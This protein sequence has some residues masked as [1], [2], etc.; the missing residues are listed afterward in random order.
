[1]DFQSG[2]N[3]NNF[4]NPLNGE[5]FQAPQNNGQYGYFPPQNYYGQ[6]PQYNQYNQFMPPNPMPP[7]QLPQYPPFVQMPTVPDVNRMYVDP[8]V[9]L[10]QCERKE[11][12]RRTRVISIPCIALMGISAFF[13][14]ALFLILL[15]FGIRQEDIYNW[16]SDGA[17]SLV[18]NMVITTLC[19][20]VPFLI[21]AKAAKFRLSDLIPLSKPKKGTGLPYFLIGI[22]F[23][24]FAN[25]LSSFA[26]I[27]FDLFGVSYS[28]GGMQL[29]E[30]NLG[31]IISVLVIS[32][33]P[34][35]MEEFAF[36]G[37]IQGLL[38]RYGEGF[39]IMTSAILFGAMHGNFEQI[40]FAFLVGL[41]CGFIR[42]KTGTMWIA[43]AVH[44]F[45]NLLSVVID[46]CF[47]TSSEALSLWYTLYL[48]AALLLGLVGV[49][50]LR[51]DKKMFVFEEPTVKY[52]ETVFDAETG[53]PY[54]KDMET[55]MP[56]T[57]KERYKAVFTHPIVIVFLSF[58]AYE[59][60]QYLAFI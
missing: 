34:G 42:Y 26:D 20:G 16:L 60:I 38:R 28:P 50:M 57:K 1:M 46:F 48:A 51:H 2:N 12:R 19:F 25:I 47:D 33:E 37:V 31:F 45:N 27:I 23:C 58:C 32:V 40:P 7:V 55:V 35:L 9:Q 3:Q 8:L 17:V 44:A 49:W 30:G 43:C 54:L 39:A 56:L 11:L 36:R 41:V 24:A 22:S 59:S 53:E 13:V 15:F 52:R 14:T 6:Y 4:N 29:P 21:A 5:N 18:L 10:K